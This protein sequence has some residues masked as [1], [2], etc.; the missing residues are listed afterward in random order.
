MSMSDIPDVQLERAGKRALLVG[1]VAA[2]ALAG[3]ALRNTDQFIRSYL[4][5]YVFWISF[6][7]GSLALLML[8]HLTGGGWGFVI[9]RLCEAGART[10]A[11]MAV[12]FL[13]LAAGM[14]RLYI[15]TQWKTAAEAHSPFKF[16]YLRPSFFLGRAVFYFAVW[17]L[18]GYLLSKWSL[19]EDSTGDLGMHRRMEAL[20]APGLILFGF[21]STF[22]VFDWAMSLEPF[23]NSTIYGMVFVVIQVFTALAFLILVARRFAEHEPLAAVASPSRFHDLGTLLFAFTML[24]GYLAFSQFLIIWAGNLRSEIPW[25]MHRGMGEWAG[26]AVF[27]LVFHFF[28][29][30][31]ILLNRPIKR[32]KQVLAR[33]A[34]ALIL[35]SA[36]D[37]F[38]LIMPAFSPTLP[39]LHPTDLLA[40]VAIGGLWFWAFTR[41]A[42]G[43]PLVPLR[44][45]RLEAVVEHGA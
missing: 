22:A 44:D 40:P 32:R 24:W 31:F 20:S 8:H 28:V 45:A 26:V 25:Y 4:F 12:L 18:L 5:A 21:T 10:F 13:P 43:R 11:L 19:E 29:P 39:R 6:P 15:W 14:S 17:I 36:V 9:R 3:L 1:L 27:L 16:A 33:V 30:F 2:M 38:W 41:E 37:V 34:A 35:V 23:W 7:L 42:R